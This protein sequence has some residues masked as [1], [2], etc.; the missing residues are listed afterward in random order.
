MAKHNPTEPPLDN[1]PITVR[2]PRAVAITGMCRSVIYQLIRAG[3]I[4]KVKI[5][6]ST[7]IPVDSLQD[8]MRRRRGG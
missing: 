1:A 8:F 5:G 6:R 4:E 2:I 7:L 3:E